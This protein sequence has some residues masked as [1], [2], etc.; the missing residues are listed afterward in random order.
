MNRRF[1]AFFLISLM[2]TKDDHLLIEQSNIHE[3]DEEGGVDYVELEHG[4]GTA[5][6]NLDNNLADKDEIEQLALARI[7]DEQYWSKLRFKTCDETYK[8]YTD[9]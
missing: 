1:A 4:S 2:G 6:S 3:V 9:Y 5:D 8:F 7:R